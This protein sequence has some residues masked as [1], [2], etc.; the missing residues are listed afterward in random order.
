M[1]TFP[2]LVIHHGR[3]NKEKNNR[4][5]ADRDTTSGRNLALHAQFTPH[6]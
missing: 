4:G 6:S 1:K 2:R 3:E 5:E